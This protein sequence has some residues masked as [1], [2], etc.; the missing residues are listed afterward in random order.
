MRETH[1][2]LVCVWGSLPRI[3]APYDHLVSYEVKEVHRRCQISQQVLSPSG[4]LKNRRRLNLNL[5]EGFR[6][7]SKSE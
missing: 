1:L 3:K 6:Q 2:L 7:S 5:S 4:P